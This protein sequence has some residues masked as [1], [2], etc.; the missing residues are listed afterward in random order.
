MESA[1]SGDGESAW[2]KT[3]AAQSAIVCREDEKFRTSNGKQESENSERKKNVVVFFLLSLL[4]LA[5][6]RRL[7]AF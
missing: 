3:A 5:A 6:R 4:F 7:S 2:G 1:G